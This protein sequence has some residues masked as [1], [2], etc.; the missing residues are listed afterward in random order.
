M[1]ALERCPGAPLGPLMPEYSYRFPLQP[2]G[3]ETQKGG[4]RGARSP[5]HIL[6]GPG[7]THPALPLQLRPPALPGAPGPTFPGA[8]ASV[9]PDPWLWQQGQAGSRSRANYSRDALGPQTP[10]RGCRG[11]RA[12]ETQGPLTRLSSFR[13]SDSLACHSEVIWGLRQ[14]PSHSEGTQPC[15]GGSPGAPALNPAGRRVQAEGPGPGSSCNPVAA[16][17]A[18]W[19]GVPCLGE[20]RSACDLP[21][22]DELPNTRVSS[23]Q[24][25]RAV[26]TGSAVSGWREGEEQNPLPSRGSPAGRRG[27][28]APHTPLPGATVP[29]RGLPGTHAPTRPPSRGLRG[30]YFLPK[31]QVSGGGSEEPGKGRGGGEVGRGRSSKHKQAGPGRGG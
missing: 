24:R 10:G 16:Q 27:P 17:V 21:I 8:P 13:L 30:L 5:L 4:A 2:Q 3:L 1:Q 18:G 31:Q 20:P 14:L 19:R 29:R 15:R 11:S 25:R 12:L 6:A 23:K 26:Y 9:S 7:R 22:L 28:C